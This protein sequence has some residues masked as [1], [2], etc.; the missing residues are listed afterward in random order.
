MRARLI[1]WLIPLT[2]LFLGTAQ[3]AEIA[4]VQPV[5]EETI[6]SNEGDLSVRVQVSGA[7]PDGGVRLVLDGAALP[8]TY[9]TDVIELIGID[10]GTHTLQALLLD[11]KGEQ[12]AASE[13]V[14]FYMWQASRL[15]PSRK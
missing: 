1:L 14:T 8:H 9:R 4:I 7:A 3:A 11:A 12:L 5:H 15:F 10:R 6:H 13:P 2:I